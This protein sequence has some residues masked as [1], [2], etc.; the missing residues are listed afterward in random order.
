MTAA[1]RVGAEG[2]GDERGKESEKFLV[3]QWKQAKAYREPYEAGEAVL[4]NGVSYPFRE[5]K[6]LTILGKQVMDT[7]EYP[8]AS[9]TINVA[10]REMVH[11][12]S[13]QPVKVLEMGFGLG[14]TANRIIEQLE[15]RRIKGEYRVVELNH[16]IYLDALEWKKRKEAEFDQK[17]REMA[18]SKPDIKIE[19]VGGEAGQEARRLLREIGSSENQKFDIIISDT[20]PLRPEDQ[21]INDIKDL[22]IL[23]KLLTSGGV[24]AFYPYV[25]GSISQ[26]DAQDGLTTKQRTIVKPYFDHIVSSSAIIYPPPEYKYLF[27]KSGP[28]RSLPVAVAVGPKTT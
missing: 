26:A 20:F 5:G 14:I 17:D 13:S 15:G 22:P 4:S 16:Q 7:S 10:F 8:W 24:F 9:E 27:R 28:V 2:N 3:E 12:N 11:P 19:I 6:R 21:G 18:G 23:V 25:P 1:E